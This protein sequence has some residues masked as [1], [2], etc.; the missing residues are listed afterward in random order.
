[1]PYLIDVWW[2]T[3]IQLRGSEWVSWVIVLS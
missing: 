1:M 2:N 3:V